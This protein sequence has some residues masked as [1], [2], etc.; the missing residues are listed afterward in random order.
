MANKLTFA[1]LDFVLGSDPGW[2]TQRASYGFANAVSEVTRAAGAASLIARDLAVVDGDDIVVHERVV[3]LTQRLI[4][5]GTPIS[6]V[7]VEGSTISGATLMLRPEAR[8]LISAVAPGVVDIKPLTTD[9]DELDQLVELCQ[10]L[11]TPADGV[12]A[13]SGNGRTLQLGHEGDS[14]SVAIDGADP[15]PVPEAD[16]YEELK[17]HMATLLGAVSH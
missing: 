16:L 7:L 13:V 11:M 15:A 9:L 14:W 5:P 2:E 1:E 6:M 3:E 17:K 8:T 10:G 4:Q 12:L